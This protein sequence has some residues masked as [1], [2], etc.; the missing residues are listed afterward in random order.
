MTPETEQ[1]GRKLAITVALMASG[2]AM[3]GLG[4]LTEGGFITLIT[5]TY[6][7]YVL[8][9]VTQKGVTNAKNDSE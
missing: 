8:G 5:M 3:F 1:L 4:M 9:N 7:G 2:I 6:G